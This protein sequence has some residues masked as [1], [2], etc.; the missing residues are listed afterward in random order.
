MSSKIDGIEHNYKDLNKRV[1]KMNIPD[2]KEKSIKNHDEHEAEWRGEQTNSNG[3]PT[4]ICFE[5]MKIGKKGKFKAKG[6]D[7]GGKFKFEGKI[8]ENKFSAKKLYE[9]EKHYYSG[10]AS[11]NESGV[12]FKVNGKWGYSKD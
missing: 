12:I 6:H 11:T 10:T 5:N 8:K 3:E 1:K 7:E 9:K 2:L 4:T